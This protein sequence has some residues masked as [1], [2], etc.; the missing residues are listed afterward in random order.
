[1]K[2]TIVRLLLL[3][4]ALCMVCGSMVACK[5]EPQEKPADDVETQDPDDKYPYP[6]KIELDDDELNIFNFDYYYNAIIY[7]DVEDYSGDKIAEEVYDRNAYFADKYGIDVVE[8]KMA[9]THRTA[10]FQEST[11][12]ISTA[13][14][15]GNAIYDI[16]YVS[17][18]EQYTLIASG[19]LQNLSE[20]PTLNLNAEWWD[21]QL[22][23]SYILKDG[24]CYVASS[25]LNLMP[26]ELTW[27]TFFNRDMVTQRGLPDLF[28][29]VRNGEWTIENMLRLVLENGI[30]NE[31]S[32]GGYDFDASGTATYG[33]AVH[34]AGAPK[35]LTG[36][37]LNFIQDR[38]HDT[39]PY[40]FACNNAE[41]FSKANEWLLRMFDRNSGMA[42]G[43]D[44]EDDL[45]GHP[46]GYVPVFQ[47]G[48]TLFLHAELKSGMT[49]KKILN[50]EINYGMLP[51]P[52]LDTEQKNYYTTTG[53]S[54][55][56]FGIPSINRKEIEA[57]GAAADVL[58]YLSYRDVLPVY[59]DDYVSFR[60][61]SD[62][63][64]LDM[65]NNYI[66]PGRRL[67][68]GVAYGWTAEFT[69]DYASLIYN[70]GASSGG[71]TLANIISTKTR[72]INSMIGN[73]FTGN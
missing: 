43:S 51:Q 14:M 69:S 17:L 5:E 25:P 23:S 8:E 50:S 38:D 46:E 40:Q 30:I 4:L 42:I 2:Q 9:F 63:D 68:I 24:A 67:E 57:I 27:L 7:T 62:P 45:D 12:K 55:M 59:Y 1:M 72:N 44:F 47:S 20:V 60:N 48:R 49:M 32:N 66:M 70:M 31:N 26:Y 3:M 11:T 53:A 71:V 34:S 19:M 18:N 21:P 29:Y 6:D 37:E 41:D 28:D 61:V 33:I 10:A 16:A 64:S 54:V 39:V 15:G 36:F 22:S 52:K 58:S 13:H 73:F 65:L 56:L 35:L